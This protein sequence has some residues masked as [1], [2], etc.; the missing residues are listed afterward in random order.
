MENQDQVI[1]TLD[2]PLTELRIADFNS[3]IYQ[4][5]SEKEL[6]TLAN[7]IKREGLVNALNVSEDLVIFDGNTRYLA[8]SKYGN[9]KTVRCNVFLGLQSDSDRFKRLL[10]SANL[11]RVK[12]TNETLRECAINSDGVLNFHSFTNEKQG[13]DGMESVPGKINKRRKLNHDYDG[14]I[15]QAITTVLN[16]LRP[17]WPI[18]LRYVHYQIVMMPKPPVISKS[19]TEGVRTYENKK[20]D[21]D[22]LS[23][24]LAKMRIEG[25][26]PMDAIRDD[27]RKVT[28]YRAWQS[29]EAYIKDQIDGLFQYY[30][31]DLLQSQ[32]EFIVLI[33]EKETV[34]QILRPLNYQYNVPIYYTKGVSSLT[35][36]HKLLQHWQSKGKR[37]IKLLFLTDFDPAGYRI[38]DSFIGSIKQEFPDII[39]GYKV[40]GKRIGI[41]LEQ[42]VKYN[43]VTTMD[44]KKTDRQHKDFVERTGQTKAYE[45][46]ALEPDILRHIVEDAIKS[47]LDMEAFNLEKSKYHQE[48]RQLEVLKKQT[49]R[50][51]S[52]AQSE[53]EE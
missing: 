37:N 50:A 45:L 19:K 29:K 27:Q 40:E 4:D 8:L 20:E 22:K 26:F 7:T 24:I 17:H 46:E 44:A 33:C 35:F 28:D 53:E 51:I 47:T 3:E 41:T 38:Q 5:R 39:K 52:K 6:R 31:R 12:T 16:K 48:R 11:Q 15:I 49:I 43:I 13:I 9:R 23:V 32:P 36:R 30:D 25:L 14:E 18:T 34:S 21:Y 1:K 2:I 42:T 10:V